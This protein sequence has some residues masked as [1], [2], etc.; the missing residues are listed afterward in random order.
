MFSLFSFF[1]LFPPPPLLLA[2]REA[3][4]AEAQGSS[5]RQL[6]SETCTGDPVFYEDSFLF[7]SFSPQVGQMRYEKVRK[8]VHPFS[9][10]FP[11]SFPLPR[12]SWRRG[13]RKFELDYRIVNLLLSPFPSPVVGSPFPGPSGDL[14]ELVGTA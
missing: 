1:S 8:S 14:V 3:Y 4:L 9:P 13:K 10:P 12:H 6:E 2:Q 5:T 7:F 11:P